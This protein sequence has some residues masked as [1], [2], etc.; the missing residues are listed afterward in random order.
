MDKL[1]KKFDSDDSGALD[2]NEL[3]ELFADNSVEVDKETI[4]TMFD[5]QKF[6]LKN[7]KSI[8][9]SEVSLK[10]NICLS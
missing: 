9:E 10:S 2:V 6:T 5:N 7:F 4:K 3:V 8:N 1:F